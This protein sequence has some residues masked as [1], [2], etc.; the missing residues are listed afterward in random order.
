M[1]AA[2]TESL[3]KRA[4]LGLVKFQI[5]LAVMIFA[6][7]VSLN[8]WQGWLF[9][10]VLLGCVLATSLYFLKHD[11]ALVR[12]RMRA[13]PTAEKEP[14]Q[15]LIQSLASLGLC[16]TVVVSA[17]DHLFGWSTVP[18]SVVIFGDLLVVL[19]FVMI[20]F[21]LRENSFA[22][23]TIGVEANQPLVS[24]GPYAIVRHPMYAGAFPMFFAT[25]IALGS[26]W[27]FVPAC[28]IAGAVIWRLL[29]EEN[30]LTRN[31]PGYADYQ[32]RV[33]WRLVPGAW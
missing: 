13:G 28:I 11:P 20:F 24:S 10:F 7:A 9:W 3:T 18:P 16:A 8:Y 21:V 1:A 17:L 29:D 22:A 15:K 30:Y 5:A 2:N 31:L 33:R 4:L 6:P 26:W 14:R 19:S 27:G 23:A 25:P 32:R 12:R